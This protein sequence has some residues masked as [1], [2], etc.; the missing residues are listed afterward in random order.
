MARA[1]AKGLA[2]QGYLA[3]LYL[4]HCAN[5][6]DEVYCVHSAPTSWYLDRGPTMSWSRLLTRAWAAIALS[7]NLAVAE[8]QKQFT[9]G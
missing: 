3:V 2:Q 8:R 6:P 9:A 1:S 4:T 7:L 5:T